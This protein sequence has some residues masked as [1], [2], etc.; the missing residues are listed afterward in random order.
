MIETRC[1]GWPEG[2]R[3]ECHVDAHPHHHPCFGDVARVD[4][5]VRGVV[6][7]R[8][9]ALIRTVV[10]VRIRRRAVEF[11]THARHIIGMCDV[12]DGLPGQIGRAVPG[13]CSECRIHPQETPVRIGHRHRDGRRSN[14]SKQGDLVCARAVNGLATWI[15]ARPC[16]HPAQQASHRARTGDCSAPMCL[17]RA[18]GLRAHGPLREAAPGCSIG[19]RVFCGL[20]RTGH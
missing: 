8:I 17:L 4:R 12:E 2:S 9:H 10:Y 19:H 5:D 6:R 1:D 15:R 20:S 14:A 18:S 11:G 3:I 7:A 16:A 13:D